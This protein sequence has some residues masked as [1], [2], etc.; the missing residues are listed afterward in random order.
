[1]QFCG[2]IQVYP[3]PL[4]MGELAYS[5][6]VGFCVQEVKDRVTNPSTR[7]QNTRE[8]TGVRQVGAYLFCRCLVSYSL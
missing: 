2:N 3:E 7:Q 6:L 5:T 4:H 8:E 1:M